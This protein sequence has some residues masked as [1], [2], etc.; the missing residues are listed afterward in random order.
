VAPRPL[1]PGVGP[2]RLGPAVALDG[3]T[4]AAALDC[5]DPRRRSPSA[6]RPGPFTEGAKTGRMFD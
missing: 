3:S 5:G 2:T 4:P 6:A 1:D